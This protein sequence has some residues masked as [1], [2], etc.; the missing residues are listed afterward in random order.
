MKRKLL[1][2]ALALL[3]VSSV[4]AYHAASCD[5]WKTDARIDSANQYG[6]CVADGGWACGLQK[7]YRDI[8]IDDGYTECLR[9]ADD[10]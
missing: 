10:I 9:N 6:E 5:V 2:V 8:R 4:R 7:W 1:V 3:A